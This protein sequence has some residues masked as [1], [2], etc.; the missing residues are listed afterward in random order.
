MGPRITAADVTLQLA[1]PRSSAFDS[2]RWVFELKFDGFRLLAERIAGQTRLIF[3]RGREATREFPEIAAELRHLTGPDFILDGELVIQDAD[4]HPVFQRLLKRSTLVAPRDIDAAMR[5]DPAVY[6]AFDLLM[7]A[8]EDLRDRPLL[9]RKRRLFEVLPRIGRV[10][11]VEHVEENGVALLEQVKVR[12]LEGIVAKK[13]DAPYRGG[14]GGSWLKIALKHVADFAIVGWADDWRALYLATWDDER[15]VYAGKVGSGFTPKL[16][17]SV[18]AELE[19]TRLAQPPCVGDPPKEKEAVWCVPSMVC[20]VRYKNWPADLSLREPAFLRFRPDK[21]PHECPTPREGVGHQS[22][23]PPEAKGVVLSH[24]SKVF[25]PDDGLTKG[26]LFA[27]YRA[28]SP[29]LLPYFRDRPLMMTRYPDGIRGKSFFQKGK[30][31]KAPSFIRSVRVR[32]EEEQRDIEQIVCD[33]QKTLEWC[34][35]MG[36][37]PFHLPAS[38]V[39][40]PERADWA[41]IDLDPKEAPFQHVVELALGLKALCDSV[42]LPSFAKLSGSTGLHVLL[43]LGGQLD[44]AGARQLAQL[45]AALLAQRFPAI[46]TLDRVVHRRGGKVYLDALQNGAGKVLAAPLCVR[47]LDGAPV[48]MTLRWDEVNEALE[49]KKYTIRNAIAHL[50]RNGDPMAPLLTLRPPLEVVLSKLATLAG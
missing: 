10:L 49:P 6:F 19:P 8:G 28:V 46:A 16:A 3:R 48:A 26:D 25:F 15:F 50:E 44:H 38:R 31:E 11:P 14:R 18:R 5:A 33:D 21:T 22:L 4:G 13:A 43:P 40:C 34:V 47:P 12:G 42:E 35:T 24:P 9:E 32:N 1:E 30:P 2:P 36:A 45:L 20:E 41:A 7:Y 23:A 29:W 39:A 37:I 27:Y 17:D